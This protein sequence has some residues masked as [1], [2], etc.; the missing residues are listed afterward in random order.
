MLC[1]V[2]DPIPRPWEHV[3]P[4]KDVAP[5]NKP[6][7]FPLTTV[8]IVCAANAMNAHPITCQAL[9]CCYQI[10]YFIFVMYRQAHMMTSNDHFSRLHHLIRVCALAGRRW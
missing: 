1:R 2:L 4:L 7:S 5:E 8:P 10:L 9:M 3:P 6:G